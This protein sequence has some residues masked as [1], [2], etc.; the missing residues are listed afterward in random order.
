M[1]DVEYTRLCR[2]IRLSS[3]YL[4]REREHCPIEILAPMCVCEEV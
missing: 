3:V 2:S 4:E 1:R